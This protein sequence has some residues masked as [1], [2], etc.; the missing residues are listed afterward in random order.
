MQVS[1]RVVYGVSLWVTN[2][3]GVHIIVCHRFWRYNAVWVCVLG[4]KGMCH[5]SQWVKKSKYV[6]GYVCVLGLGLSCI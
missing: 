3:Q 4:S 6:I 1:G 5:R 2:G